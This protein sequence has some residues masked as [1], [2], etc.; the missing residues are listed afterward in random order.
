MGTIKPSPKL[1]VLVT[2]TKTNLGCQ[3]GSPGLIWQKVQEP[4]TQGP[5]SLAVKLSLLISLLRFIVPSL[6]K[7]FL[8]TL[9]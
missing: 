3:L 2:P 7:T 1:V 4:L 8:D 6:L 5:K 9:Q